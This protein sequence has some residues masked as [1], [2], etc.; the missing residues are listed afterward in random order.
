MHKPETIF[1]LTILLVASVV[2]VR[3]SSNAAPPAE[4]KAASFLDRLKV[5]QTVALTEKGGGFEIGIF[6]KE[7]QPLGHTVIEIGRDYCTFRALGNVIESTIPI[8]SIKS[9]NV[10]RVPAK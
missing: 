2:A 6:P 8:Y 9:I 10:I 4:Q 1:Y 5:G 7:I 3:S